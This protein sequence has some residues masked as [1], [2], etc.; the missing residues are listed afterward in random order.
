MRSGAGTGAETGT[1]S[2]WVCGGSRVKSVCVRASHFYF[3]DTPQ[4]SRPTSD[5]RCRSVLV[6]VSPSTRPF[7]TKTKVGETAVHVRGQRQ[8]SV[9]LEDTLPRQNRL[10]GPPLAHG[11]LLT[12]PQ[13]GLPQGVHSDEALSHRL[14]DVGAP[15]YVGRILPDH[16]GSGVEGSDTPAL[17]DSLAAQV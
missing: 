5:E 14:R 7:R 8:P 16:Q 1:S 3:H 13:T 4:P 10:R 9:P 17:H 6:K 11:A 2:P 12:P 15:L